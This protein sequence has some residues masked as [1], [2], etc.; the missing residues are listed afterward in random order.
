MDKKITIL[1][2]LN[3]SNSLSKIH[4]SEKIIH[5]LDDHPNDQYKFHSKLYIL[6]RQTIETQ[7][8]LSFQFHHVQLDSINIAPIIYNP[9]FHG[10]IN[11][12]CLLVSIQVYREKD[13]F[14]WLWT[15]MLVE[16]NLYPLLVKIWHYLL[17]TFSLHISPRYAFSGTPGKVTNRFVNSSARACLVDE[18]TLTLSFTSVC[19]HYS[20]FL[21]YFFPRFALSL[22]FEFTRLNVRLKCYKSFV[23]CRFV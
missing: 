1:S 19:F 11:T 15:K 6:Y 4:D 8:D 7:T 14:K 10:I 21:I 18:F 17:H 23:Y 5:L 16:S 9:Y 13:L 3:F 20:R 12:L 22:S 2:I